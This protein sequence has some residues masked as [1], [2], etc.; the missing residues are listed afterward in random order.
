MFETHNF[1]DSFSYLKI[2]KIDNLWGLLSESKFVLA[3][4]KYLFKHS[5]VLEK[6][7]ISA[8][9]WN[10]TGVTKA[11]KIISIHLSYLFLLITFG[12]YCLYKLQPIKPI[13]SRKLSL[14][15]LAKCV[16]WGYYRRKEIVGALKEKLF[17]NWE[18]YYGD[19]LNRLE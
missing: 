11:S 7:F 17:V 9:C 18:V 19:M 16:C 15:K 2:V 10:D 3:L 12:S 14:G 6:N 13:L 1:N 5:I 4:V 8:S